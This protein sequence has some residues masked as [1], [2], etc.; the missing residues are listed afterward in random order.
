MP[1][2]CFFNWQRRFSRIH[3]KNV[4]QYPY[5]LYTLDGKVVYQNNG[6]AE[7]ATIKFWDKAFKESGLYLSRVWVQDALGNHDVVGKKVVLVR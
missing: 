1:D 5:E 4:Q 3:F 7:R 2:S 6:F